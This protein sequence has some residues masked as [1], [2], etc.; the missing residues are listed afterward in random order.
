MK[1]PEYYPLCASENLQI[2]ETGTEI[3]AFDTRETKSFT[4]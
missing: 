3:I 4:F 2:E 1:Q